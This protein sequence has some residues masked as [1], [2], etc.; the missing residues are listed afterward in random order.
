MLLLEFY[1][2][3][4]ETLVMFL[5]IVFGFSSIP[6]IA[7]DRFLL[8]IYHPRFSITKDNNTRWWEDL[9]GLTVNYRAIVYKKRL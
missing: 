6:L 7:I 5:L 9:N 3:I 2:P 1:F 4:P 8:F